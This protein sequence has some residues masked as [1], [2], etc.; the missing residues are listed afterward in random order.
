MKII[1]LEFQNINNLKG[2]H[3]IDFSVEPLA[4]A[5]I[6]AITGATGS[7]KSTILDVITLALFN[8]TPRFNRISK[9]ALAE[10]GSIITRNE[11]Q[12]E[13]KIT[14]EIKGEEYVSVWNIEYNRNHNLK[15]YHMEI[16]LNGR[17]LDLKK[18]EVPQK[19]EQIIGLDYEQFTKAI[20]L[21]QGEFSK[22]LKADKKQ[23][24]ELLEKITGTFIYRDL[25]I[26][27]FEQQRESRIVYEQK[28][29]VLTAITTLSDEEKQLLIEKQKS[30]Q[31]S[32]D[33]DKKELK[34]LR[35]TLV[36]KQEYNELSQ[37]IEK[38]QIY[39]EKLKKQE[40]GFTTKQQQLDLHYKVFPF[41]KDL[42][43]YA[44]TTE[45]LKLCEINLTKYKEQL[46]VEIER[47]EKVIQDLKNIVK[48]DVTETNFLQKNQDFEKKVTQ[49]V[50]DLIH[51]QN[52]GKE[53]RNDLNQ[54]N[55]SELLSEYSFDVSKLTAQDV[56]SEINKIKYFISKRNYSVDTSIQIIE[57]DGKSLEL[58][59]ADYKLLKSYKEQKEE[60][61]KE[62]EITQ[63]AVEILGK[64]LE[65]LPKQIVPLN[66][67]KETSE[68]QLE[69]LE[70]KKTIVSYEEQRKDLKDNEE[71][72]LCGSIHHP[73]ANHLDIEKKGTISDKIDITKREIEELSRQIQ[74][75]ETSISSKKMQL[76]SEEKN[77]EKIKE[78]TV[79]LGVRTQEKLYQKSLFE[80]VLE[81][82]ISHL[83]KVAEESKATV[84]KMVRSIQK[85]GLLKQLRSKI[86]KRWDLIN[87]LT[88]TQ[89]EKNRLYEGDDVSKRMNALQNTF[90]EAIS[91]AKIY[92]NSID[93]ENESK[94]TT[95][96]ELKEL[97]NTIEVV[98]NQ[99]NI[100][101]LE[102]LNKAVLSDE[103]VQKFE[104]E[105]QQINNEKT[106]TKAL[107]KENQ[108]KKV[109]VES[110]ELL[111]I[112]IEVLKNDLKEKEQSIDEQHRVLGNTTAI[113]ENDKKLGEQRKQQIIAVK[114]A[115]K[116]YLRWKKL[117]D[118]IGDSQGHKF[119]TFAQGLTLQHLIRFTNQ[120]LKSLSGRYLI[121]VEP[122]NQD[123]MIIDQLQGNTERSVKTLSGG[124]SF[125]VS[126]ALA[127]SLS[128]MA[129]KNVRLE[130][131]FIDEGFGTLDEDTLE[132]ALSLL[133]KLQ[134]E[135]NK[136][137]GVISHVKELKERITTQI[138]L[139]KNSQGHSRITVV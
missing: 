7:G 110:Q 108:V 24:S 61:H 74:Q 60:L 19:N 76:E 20:I 33:K 35:D 112:D 21:S 95:Q 139:T 121:Y 101:S 11:R 107:L 63:K 123:L 47:K 117:S 36:K 127:L 89:S 129:S 87:K 81:E 55:S 114:V 85:I 104:G 38:L 50:N 78:K 17:P 72:P 23:R 94:E 13:A 109:A 2:R 58:Q 99:T 93:K 83:I 45:K 100:Y 37:Q 56:D 97:S 16:L 91:N 125:L 77:I 138:Q 92:Q 73:F 6:F 1:K 18:S 126:L 116:E 5:D 12:A 131:L 48:E 30:I 80:S 39:Q 34:T 66:Q 124:E 25:G 52:N 137:V 51:I 41:R 64:D 88:A 118:L 29:E 102:A 105:K 22:F 70:L 103:T 42:V 4:T 32:V 3:C 67:Q 82:D 133:E 130:S 86:E 71:C 135:S 122:K 53:L 59:I 57:E 31:E 119:S 136:K 132:K 27:A 120:R 68:L 128:D 90:N 40:E 54:L 96:N 65:E 98:K 8:R 69:N 75:I 15:D 113:L 106:K 14:Y 43:D 46:A 26:R 115:E 9:G 134:S 111:S 62:H 84:E 49:F 28:K 10:Q 79:L 44:K